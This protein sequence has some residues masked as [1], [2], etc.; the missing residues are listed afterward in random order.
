[1]NVSR[2]RTFM[3]EV[4]SEASSTDIGDIT[5]KSRALDRKINDKVYFL[6]DIDEREKNIIEEA[7]DFGRPYLRY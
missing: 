4:K 2:V 7:I 1:V 5:Q 6:Y 3:A